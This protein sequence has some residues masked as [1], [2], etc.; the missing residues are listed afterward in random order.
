MGNCAAEIQNIAKILK[1]KR[2][3][4]DISPLTNG[5]KKGECNVAKLKFNIKDIPRNTK[6][7]LSILDVL[8]DVA[9]ME[10]KNIDIPISHYC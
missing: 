6:P 10:T 7:V 2:L 3:C 5:Y 4:L 8:L 9:Y 1:K